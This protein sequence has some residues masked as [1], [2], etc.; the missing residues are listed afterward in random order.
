[1]SKRHIG[2]KNTLIHPS[3]GQTAI[4]LSIKSNTKCIYS[5]ILCHQ[6]SETFAILHYFYT[7]RMNNYASFKIFYL[8]LKKDFSE[9]GS[10]VVELSDLWMLV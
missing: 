4:C 1:M 5:Q 7:I 8:G 3:M 6:T 10:N 2:K 9:Q